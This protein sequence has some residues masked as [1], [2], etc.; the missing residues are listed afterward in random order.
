[1]RVIEYIRSKMKL[2]KLHM[3]LIDPDKQSQKES[4]KIAYIAYTAGSDAIMVGGSTGIDFENLNKSV[5]AMK[6]KV[7]IPIIQFPSHS[8]ALSPNI[9]AIYFM[10]M[11]NSMDINYIIG[12]QMRA[13][14][15]IKNMDI[16]T[17]PM[18]YVI[19]EPG[20]KVG[21]MGSADPVK[22]DDIKRAIGYGVAAELLG[23]NLY[24]LEAGSGAP[25]PVPEDMVKAVSD[26]LSI[27]LVVGGGIRDAKSASRIADAGADIVVTG[28]IVEESE[29]IKGVLESI[30]SGVK[31]G[32]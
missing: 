15:A 27:P 24:Y 19:V 23:M 29:D 22:R 32:I 9:D 16:E 11:L 10:S 3:T 12:E 1:M 14:S 26:S 8:K 18:G 5:L 6:E 7:P 30:V 13:A 28:T 31:E 25:E 4:A 17:I 21:E 20:M 2:G